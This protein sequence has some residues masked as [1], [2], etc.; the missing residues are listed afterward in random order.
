[1]RDQIRELLANVGGLGVCALD[2]SA[3]ADLYGLGLKSL[4]V[5]RLM[6][7][8]EHALAVEFSSEVLGRETF[9][10]IGSIERAVVLMKAQC[11]AGSC[12]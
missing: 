9:S 2:V 8:L 7:A 6:V 12:T 4:A 3:D 10:S 5:V 1:M 11:G